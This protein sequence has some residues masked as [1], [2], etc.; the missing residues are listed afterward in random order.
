MKTIFFFFVLIFTQG[1][2]GASLVATETE[3]K[4]V[5]KPFEGKFSR[6]KGGLYIPSGSCTEKISN[7]TDYARIYSEDLADDKLVALKTDSQPKLAKYYKLMIERGGIRPLHMPPENAAFARLLK[8]APNHSLVIENLRDSAGEP[9]QFANPILLLGEP[10]IGKSHFAME[11]AAEIG[12]DFDLIDMTSLSAGWLLTGNSAGYSYATP[13]RVAK[14]LVEGNSA[15]PIFVLDEID[16]TPQKQNY[17]PLGP[18]H[19]L[20][21]IGSARRFVDEFIEIPTDASHIIWIATANDPS[22][23]PKT[24]LDRMDVYVIRV[25]TKY[26]FMDIGKSIYSRILKEHPR[27]KFNPEPKENV[28]EKLVGVPPRGMRKVLMHAFPKAFVGHR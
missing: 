12:T 4:A 24:I 5:P 21:E 26:E 16:K 6:S 25:P 18:F 10:G 17:D 7:I 28:L 1:S 9:M 19:G 2:L 3:L 22:A 14:T 11:L 8:A 27:W 23:I 20:M 13:G 15:N